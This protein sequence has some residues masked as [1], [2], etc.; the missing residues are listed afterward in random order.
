MVGLCIIPE[1]RRN[2][3]YTEEQKAEIYKVS[4]IPH[5]EEY[6]SYAERNMLGVMY[7]SVKHGLVFADDLVDQSPKHLYS[8]NTAQIDIWSKVVAE[9]IFRECLKR[10]VSKVFLM[11]RRRGNYQPLMKEL[12]VRGIQVITPFL[13]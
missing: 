5:I 11:V 13:S 8:Y 2:K 7:I 10:M 3:E 12:K 9:Q 4:I 6:L 1:G